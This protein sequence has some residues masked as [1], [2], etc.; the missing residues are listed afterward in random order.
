MKGSPIMF[1][2]T[3]VEKMSVSSLAKMLLKNNNL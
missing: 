2:K 1:L 3:H